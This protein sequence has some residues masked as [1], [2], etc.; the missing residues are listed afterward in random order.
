MHCQQKGCCSWQW[1]WQRNRWQDGNEDH[2]NM[3]CVDVGVGMFTY[4][5]ICINVCMCIF[6]CVYVRGSFLWCLF[7]LSHTE[8]RSFYLCVHTFACQNQEED[9]WMGKLM[10]RRKKGKKMNLHFSVKQSDRNCNTSWLL[11]NS[12]SWG[13]PDVKKGS[14]ET[15]QNFFHFP[16]SLF[17]IKCALIHYPQKSEIINSQREKTSDWR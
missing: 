6:V 14:L 11:Q 7:S 4:I 3:V 12:D 10:R 17:K 9:K 2:I 15:S 8:R 13:R 5:Y 1:R 16:F